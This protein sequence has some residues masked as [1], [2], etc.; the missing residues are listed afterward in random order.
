MF[1]WENAI[2]NRLRVLNNSPIDLRVSDD[3][4]LKKESNDLRGAPESRIASISSHVLMFDIVY[5]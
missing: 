4:D 5:P 2:L 3:S 1:D